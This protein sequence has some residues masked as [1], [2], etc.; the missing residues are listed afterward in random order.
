MVMMSHINGVNFRDRQGGRPRWFA[1]V[2]QKERNRKSSELR[3]KEHTWREFCLDTHIDSNS[4][5]AKVEV[6]LVT[7][8]LLGVRI[9]LTLLAQT[10]QNP[11]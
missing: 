3:W 8:V 7:L 10:Q 6:H 11:M 4:K 2:V 9:V 5:M 1:M